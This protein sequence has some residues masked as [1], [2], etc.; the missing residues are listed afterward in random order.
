MQYGERVSG[1]ETRGARPGRSCDADRNVR[2]GTPSRDAGEHFRDH[3]FGI[4]VNV[5]WE[6]KNRGAVEAFFL[7]GCRKEKP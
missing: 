4:R 7:I 5:R 1:E 2:G 3:G 6:F